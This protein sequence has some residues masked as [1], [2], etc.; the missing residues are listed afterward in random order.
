MLSSK[1]CVP[2]K[3]KKIYLVLVA[4]GAQYFGEAANKP[5]PLNRTTTT[6]PSFPPSQEVEG[7][8]AISGLTLRS[9]C[10]SSL[11]LAEG[12]L[13]LLMAVLELLLFLAEQGVGPQPQLAGSPG[14]LGL[15]ICF[16]IG[17]EGTQEDISEF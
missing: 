6:P 5:A 10:C 16:L 7:K 13:I 12:P 3:V 9:R 11:Q 14:Q 4:S 1:Y 8:S 2:V 17:L 15:R